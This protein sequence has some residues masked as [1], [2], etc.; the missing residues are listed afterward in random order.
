MLKPIPVWYVGGWMVGIVHNEPLSLLDVLNERVSRAPDRVLYRFLD[1]NQ[2]EVAS[3]TLRELVIRGRAIGASLQC[4]QAPGSTAL[5]LYPPG[6]SFIEAFFGCLFGGVVPVPVS[7]PDPVRFK[8]TLPRLQ[9]IARDADTRS[10]LTSGDLAGQR[11]RITEEAASLAEMEWTD[12]D[13]V[14]D[15]A[16][17]MLVERRPKQEDV[18]FLQYTSGSTS[19]P[20][21][22]RVTHGNLMANE[23]FIAEACGLAEE[24]R[25]VSW[26]PMFHDMGLIGAVLQPLYSGFPV[27]FLSPVTF[28]RNPLSWLRAISDFRATIS[29]APNFAYAYCT[30]RVTDDEVSSLDLSSWKCALNGA[31]PVS[32]V[33]LDRFARKFR[34]AGFRRHAFYPCYGLAESTLLVSGAKPAEAE[35]SVFH[36]VKSSLQEG[37]AAVKPF[38]SEETRPLVSCG[39]TDGD[40]RVLIVDPDTEEALEEGRVGEI[41]IRGPS[42]A[43]GY[44]TQGGPSEDPFHA[45]LSTGDSEEYLRTGDLGFLYGREL[46]V[47]GRCKDLIVIRGKNHYPQDIEVTVEHAHIAVVQGGVAAFSVDREGEERLVLAVEATSKRLSPA[48]LEEID[49]RVREA[50]TRE[51]DV[52]VQVVAIV[53]RRTLPK[54]SSG[55]LRRGVCRDRFLEGTLR[56]LHSGDRV[57]ELE[58]PVEPEGIPDG[59]HAPLPAREGG[60]QTPGAPTEGEIREW[61]FRQISSHLGIPREAIDPARTFAAYGLDSHVAVEMVDAAET[62]LQRELDPVMFYNYPTVRHLV[63]YLSSP[64]S[65][66]PE[67]GSAHQT[68]KKR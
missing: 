20:R 37:R 16:A 66:P 14:G 35:P 8:R 2:E 48:E 21:G 33:V 51:H 3:L 30:R 49:A 44:W 36:V 28:L 50:V 9:V 63:R 15:E 13:T 52:A 60:T 65:L 5:L 4:L 23:R 46:V 7:A 58:E 68:K 1:A 54:T 24:D 32:A 42:V 55:K 27:R 19:K 34:M 43:E 6:L 47:T 62:W 40:H 57:S 12:T 61:L 67:T 45:R 38:A 10:I 17:S 22:V 64:E 56:V 18:A 29:P 41:W 11:R 25:G 31:E 39:A 53:E 59:G 26:L